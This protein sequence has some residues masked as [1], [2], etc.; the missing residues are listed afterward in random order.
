MEQRPFS[1][2]RSRETNRGIGY[3][4]SATASE[5]GLGERSN[6]IRTRHQQIDY[7]HP[8][9]DSDDSYVACHR[10]KYLTVGIGPCTNHAS[11]EL[12][13]AYHDCRN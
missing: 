10:S 6:Y 2:S 7:A 8:S 5:E 12:W 1:E 13:I 3:S 9:D 11:S 4:S